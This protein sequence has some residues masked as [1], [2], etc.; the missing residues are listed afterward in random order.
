MIIFMQVIKK[1]FDAFLF[2]SL[3]VPDDLDLAM[4]VK[5]DH[6]SIH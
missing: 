5:E 2:L 4:T 6:V 3:P 1:S